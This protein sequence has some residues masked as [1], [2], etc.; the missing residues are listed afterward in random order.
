MKAR[1]VL[2]RIKELGGRVLRQEGS[3][4]RV[5]CRCGT[6]K[7]TVPDW[8]PYDLKRGTLGSIQRALEPCF[9]KGWL[10]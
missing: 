7:A 3:H 8:G 2:R 5:C 4:V 1:D 9:G 6:Y 10:F